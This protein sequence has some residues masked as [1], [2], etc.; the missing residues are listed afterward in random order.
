MAKQR[1]KHRLSAAY[2]RLTADIRTHVDWKWSDGKI[3][4]M[5][6]ETERKLYLYWMKLTLKTVIRDKGAA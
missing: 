2:K 4:S 1:N 3:Y 6:T 5:Q